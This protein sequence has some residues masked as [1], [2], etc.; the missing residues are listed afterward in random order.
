MIKMKY[1]ICSY[2]SLI[3][4]LSLYVSFRISRWLKEYI[5]KPNLYTKSRKKWKTCV[6]YPMIEHCE[7]DGLSVRGNF[8][9]CGC[10]ASFQINGAQ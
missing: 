4:S 1:Y 3:C 10:A 5:F 8:V 2:A 9:R 6:L 7:F